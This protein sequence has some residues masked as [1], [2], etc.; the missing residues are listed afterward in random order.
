MGATQINLGIACANLP[1][2]DLPT[3]VANL[4]RAIEC[5]EAALRVWTEG[6]SPYD[7]AIPRDS[8]G[9][10]YSYLPTGDR[11]NNLRRAIKCYGAALR[12]WTEQNS[13]QDWAMTKSN[14]GLACANLPT[15]DLP[16]RVA[17]LQRAMNATR[18]RCGCKPERD[19]PYDWA[20]TRT[21]LAS[22]VLT[23]RLTI[24]LPRR[25]FAAR[26]RMLRGGCARV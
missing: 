19:S 16:T 18:R 21:T 20:V 26:D 17:N 14:L 4:Q 25:Q 12:V 9:I 22:P 13:P 3:R 2:D 8:L 1:T 24:R 10:Y 15:K 11:T 5:C 23:Y 7:W 6:N